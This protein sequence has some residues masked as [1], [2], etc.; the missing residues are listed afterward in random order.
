MSDLA[1]KP[2]MP[3]V[4]AVKLKAALIGLASYATF[5]LADATVKLQSGAY[6]LAQ[7]T[8]MLEISAA[9]ILLVVAAGSGRVKSVI[10]RQPVFTYLRALLLAIETAMIYYAFATIPMPEAYV[11]AFLSPIFVAVMSFLVFKERLTA[12]AWAG[13]V[14]GF[15]GVIV[16]LRPGAGGFMPGHLAAIGSSILFSITLLMVKKAHPDESNTA[17]AFAPALLLAV[18]ATAYLAYSGEWT[19]LTLPAAATFFAGGAAIVGGS[20]FLVRAFR[21]GEP[22]LVAPTQYSQIVWGT[23]ISYLLFNTGIDAYTIAGAAIIIVSGLLV[24]K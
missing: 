24:L 4:S 17:L 11:L 3:S 6:P 19:P 5:T 7:V 9:L 2:A 12:L 10:P 22:S 13:V 15:I 18:G 23:L 1:A 16:A 8:L 20:M 14:L 21:L